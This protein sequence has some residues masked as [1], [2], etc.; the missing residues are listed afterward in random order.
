MSFNVGTLPLRLIKRKKQC[1]RD[2]PF[3]GQK[4][5]VVIEVKCDLLHRKIGVSVLNAMNGLIIAPVLA[6]E[7]C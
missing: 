5:C 7:D 3:C 2:L 4:D 6:D 1:D